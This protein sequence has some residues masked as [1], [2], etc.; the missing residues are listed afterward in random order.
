MTFAWLHFNQPFLKELL[1]IEKPYTTEANVTNINT[2]YAIRDLTKETASV[3]VFWAGGIPSP[4]T[5]RNTGRKV[6]LNLVEESSP[7]VLLPESRRF[8]DFSQ[9]PNQ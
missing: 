6:V 9:R 1:L 2:A 3:G 5:V 8:I 7:A 4:G